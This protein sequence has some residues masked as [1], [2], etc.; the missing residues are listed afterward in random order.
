MFNVFN[1]RWFDRIYMGG[2]EAPLV[3]V[4]VPTW[5]PN[6]VRKNGADPQSPADT[7]SSR[8]RATGEGEEP[9]VSGTLGM[10]RHVGS[11]A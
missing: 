1:V 7:N 5:E 2:W 6:P 11:G 9:G 8:R 10:S 3:H 4:F